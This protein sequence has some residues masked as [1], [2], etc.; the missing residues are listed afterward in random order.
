MRRIQWSR[1]RGMGMLSKI[2]DLFCKE[3]ICIGD[4]R[5]L[6]FVADAR[7]ELPEGRLCAIIV[8]GPSRC[9]GLMGCR[10]DYVIPW[11]CICR[12]GPDIILVDIKPEDCRCIRAK[13]GLLG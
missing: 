3:V 13:Q 11:H 9:F 5:R 6:G 10:D 1:K 2:S 7:L 8:P 12:I 4:G